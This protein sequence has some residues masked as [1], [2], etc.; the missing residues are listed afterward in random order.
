MDEETTKDLAVKLGWKKVR[1][2]PYP[3]Y[4]LGIISEAS[5]SG[6]LVETMT[7]QHLAYIT[8]NYLKEIREQTFQEMCKLEAA[9]KE[10][11]V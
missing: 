1:S 4:T 10:L 7:K 9:I 6:H 5:I 8:R 2:E 11:D 3:V